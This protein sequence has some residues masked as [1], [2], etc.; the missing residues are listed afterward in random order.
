MISARLRLMRAND[1]ADY[2]ADCAHTLP[3]MISAIVISSTLPSSGPS[4]ARNQNF[5][6]VVALSKWARR[7]FSSTSESG[8]E[9]QTRSERGRHGQSGKT[10]SERQDTVRAGKR[11]LVVAGEA[12]AGA[13]TMYKLSS[14]AMM[15]REARTN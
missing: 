13:V 11:A 9:E 12:M 15:T 14:K 2:R 1:R 6:D 4:S 3:A 7:M 5:W 8:C 10:R